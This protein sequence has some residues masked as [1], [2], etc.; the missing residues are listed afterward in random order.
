MRLSALGREALFERPE[1]AESEQTLRATSRPGRSLIPGGDCQPQP[2]P[3]KAR[4]LEE[5]NAPG[6]FY[7]G[8]QSRSRIN[9]SANML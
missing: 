6:R 5:R 3:V 1:Q 2:P 7:A 8:A 9:S 4:G